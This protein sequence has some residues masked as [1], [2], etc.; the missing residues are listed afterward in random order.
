[1][2]NLHLAMLTT[3]AHRIGRNKIAVG[4]PICFEANLPIEEIE[5]LAAI[6]HSYNPTSPLVVKLITRA[7]VE[8]EM[9]KWANEH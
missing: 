2:N 7:E 9:R 3:E 5:R 1:M 4:K 6:I 8:A